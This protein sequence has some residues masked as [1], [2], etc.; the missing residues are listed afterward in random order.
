[1][2]KTIGQILKQYI[3]FGISVIVTEKLL[4]IYSKQHIFT[5]LG[6]IWLKNNYCLLKTKFC[7]WTTSNML[8]S[9]VMITFLCWTENTLF[10]EIWSKNSKLF[11]SDKAWYLVYF[12]Y[13]EFDGDYH[14][15]ILNRKYV[16]WVNLV[17]KIKIVC[18]RGNLATKLIQICWI[19]WWCSFI[20]LWKG[21]SFLEKF[22]SK[23][24]NCLLKMKFSI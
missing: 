18:S 16:F 9:M 22:W 12:K 21:T 10:E 1:M 4:V 24:Q 17:Q 11:V 19:P 7:I 2:S 8:N 13:D 6:Q 14:F 5:L 20:L 3:F 23:N 15:F